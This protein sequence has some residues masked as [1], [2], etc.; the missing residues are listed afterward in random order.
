M[1]PGSTHIIRRVGST[2]LLIWNL[3][4]LYH[5]EG[6]TADFAAQRRLPRSGRCYG[7]MLSQPPDASRPLAA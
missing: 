1:L 4:Q 2:P 6:G 3:K 7:S 5:T